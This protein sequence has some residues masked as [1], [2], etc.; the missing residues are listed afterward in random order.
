MPTTGGTSSEPVVV[1]TTLTFAG[2]TTA[3]F[4]SM[5]TALTTVVAGQFG[6][7]ASKV[8]LSLASSGSRRT[9]TSADIIAEI[10]AEDQAEMT[11][12]VNQIQ[13]PNF[14][15]VLTDLIVAE[16]AN[17]SSLNGV[18]VTGKTTPT[19]V[20]TTT[21]TTTTAATTTTTTTTASEGTTTT[22]AA[23]SASTL[24]SLIAFIMSAYMF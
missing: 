24:M 10:E 15:N 23:G 20:T 3:N 17:D 16:A 1:T 12:F 5:K 22:T 13:Q 21:T 6:V 11:T 9:L 4:D 19:I 7:D 14:V 2:V 18:T 8:T